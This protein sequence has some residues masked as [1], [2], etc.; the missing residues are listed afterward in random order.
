MSFSENNSNS[1]VSFSLKS[2]LS[3]SDDYE[4]Q[5]LEEIF[6]YN[7]EQEEEKKPSVMIV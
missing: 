5:I 4:H 6:L 7:N 1:K 2:G 3:D